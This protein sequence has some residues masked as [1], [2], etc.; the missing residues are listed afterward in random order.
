MRVGVLSDLGD[1]GG[2]G[3]GVAVR[4]EHGKADVPTRAAAS[5]L[6]LFLYN[7]RGSDGLD[8][9]GDGGLVASWSERVTF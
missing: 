3:D 4:R 5:D 7:R 1:G 9:F 2:V 8:V 6:E